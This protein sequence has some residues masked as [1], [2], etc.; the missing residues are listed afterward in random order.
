MNK[1]MQLNSYP[2]KM[3]K[4]PRVTTMAKLLLMGI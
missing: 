3:K 4:L 2:S 1:F